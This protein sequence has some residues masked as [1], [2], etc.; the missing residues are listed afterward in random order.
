MCLKKKVVLNNKIFLRTKDKLKVKCFLKQFFSI[1]RQSPGDVKSQ[2]LKS[3][4]N[5]TG[6]KELSAATIFID[7]VILFGRKHGL[8]NRNGDWDPRIFKTLVTISE[9]V[10]LLHYI[11]YYSSLAVIYS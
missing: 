1:F 10:L 9:G 11:L 8:I 2:V 3:I 6:T 4:L 5:A 7:D